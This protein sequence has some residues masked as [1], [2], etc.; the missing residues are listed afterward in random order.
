MDEVITIDTSV[1]HLSSGLAKKTQLI[2]SN[3]PDWRW[4]LKG[5]Q[6]IW[7]ENTRLIRSKAEDEEIDLMKKIDFNFK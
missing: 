6:S 5:D 4:R 2:L 1:A 7:Y 3:V